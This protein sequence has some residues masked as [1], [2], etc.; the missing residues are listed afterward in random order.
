MNNGMGRDFIEA[1]DDGGPYRTWQ[2]RHADA[3]E[4]K[5]LDMHV[6]WTVDD[7]VFVHTGNTDER[8]DGFV[9]IGTLE[10]VDGDPEHTVSEDEAYNTDRLRE[11]V[12]AWIKA[13]NT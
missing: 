4:I 12:C 2:H 6:A 1:L 9:H 10:W 5:V 13:N 3:I 8:E 11:Y 7:D